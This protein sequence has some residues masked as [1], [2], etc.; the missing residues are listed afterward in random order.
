[1]NAAL[2]ALAAGGV[3]ALLSACASTPVAPPERSY[4]G[5][6]AAT[7]TRGSETQNVSGR[8]SLEVR[9]TEQVFDLA[10]PIGTTIARVEIG[11]NGA[12]A[13]G[14]QLDE[15]RGDNADALA[16]RLLGWPLPVGGL[17]DWIEGRPV[18]GRPARVERIDGR[19]ASIV[20][21]GWTIQVAE[22]FEA[23]NQ[24]APRRPRRLVIE[25]PASGPDPA[26]TVRLIL[27]DPV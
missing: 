24:V 21:D 5:R 23:V 27:D 25:R 6:F 20:Q 15:V 14:P 18:P 22:S 12:R 2:R 11:P 13:R 10:T 16:E 19:V 8:F 9:G 17:A 7:A 3:I 1:M 4:S 26:V